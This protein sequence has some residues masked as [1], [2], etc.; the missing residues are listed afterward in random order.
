[1]TK[2][3]NDKALESQNSAIGYIVLYGFD[4]NEKPRA[5]RFSSATN[6]QLLAKA[7]DAMS[8]KLS[9]A[10]TPA[11]IEIAEKLPAGRLY[12]NGRGFVPYVRAGLFEKLTA[13]LT[14]NSATDPAIPPAGLPSGWN[15][16]DLGHLV[17]AH[18]GAAEG[19]WEAIVVEKNDDMLTLRWRDYPRLAQVVRHR[20]SVALLYPTAP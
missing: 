19:W 7:A 13:A 3:A 12:S 11:L 9:E 8:V 14:G 6:R 1:M 10:T 18:E 4:E 2:H 17:I 15:D 16:I 5:A 20:A